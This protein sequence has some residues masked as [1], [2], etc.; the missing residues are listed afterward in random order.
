MINT[1]L[2]EKKISDSGMTMFLWQ[3]R[4]EFYEKAYI[5]SLKETR[6]LKLLKFLVYQKC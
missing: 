4:Q 6:N 1:K 5:I 2:L 3:K